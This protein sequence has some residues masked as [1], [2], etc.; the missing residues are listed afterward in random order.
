ML[1]RISFFGI[2]IA[3]IF[4]SNS[5][6][7][8]Q[9]QANAIY[10]NNIENQ[11]FDAVIVPGIPFNGQQWDNVMKMR[12]LWAA[13]L[14]KEGITKHVIFS[15][16]AVYTH[17]V[18][19]EIMRQYA[20]AMGVDSNDILVE[21]R[22]E[23]ST[24][25]VYYSYILAREQSWTNVALATDLVQSKMVKSFIAKRQLPVSFLPVKINIIKDIPTPDNIYIDTM[26]AYV[27]NFKSITETQTQKYRWRGTQGKNIDFK[28]YR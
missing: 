28:K 5:C 12:V 2:I 3:L 14:Y 24:E 20:I 7:L 27:P 26:R 23:H 16:S 25:N 15:G 19:G 8:Y 17:F 4:V 13:Y 21:T 10:K 6:V 9:F 22:A 18:E 1:K 11:P